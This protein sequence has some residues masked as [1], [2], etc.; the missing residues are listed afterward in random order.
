[1]PSRGLSRVRGNSH[2]RFLGRNGTVMCCSYPTLDFNFMH[3]SSSYTKL[4]TGS[5]RPNPAGPLL[6]FCLCLGTLL[7]QCPN[8]TCT[9]LCLCIVFFMQ[10]RDYFFVV[11]FYRK[12]PC[13]SNKRFFFLTLH[14]LQENIGHLI[15]SFPNAIV[16]S[17]ELRVKS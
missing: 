1:M 17:R 14:I 4:G 11:F 13:L 2:A 12:C 15:F 10:N 16:K 7:V 5:T 3:K 9:Y 8:I 6:I